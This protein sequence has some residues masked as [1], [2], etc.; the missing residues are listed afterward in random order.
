MTAES[1]NEGTGDLPDPQEILDALANPPGQPALQRAI[2]GHTDSLARMRDRLADP[3]HELTLRSLARAEPGEPAVA[4]LDAWAVVA[5]TVS[6]YSERIANEAFLR[7]AVRLPS[8]REL[9]RTLGYELRPG[10]AAQVELAF[11]VED[12]PGGSGSASP[13]PAGVVVP[14]GTPVQSIPGP[15]ELPQTFRTTTDLEARAQWNRLVAIDSRPQVQPGSVASVWVRGPAAV[16][17]GDTVLVVSR[18]QAAGGGGS[19]STRQRAVRVVVEVDAAAQPGW[20]RLDLDQAL[21]PEE[22]GLRE[23]VT[24]QAFQRRLRLFGWNAPDHELVTGDTGEWTGFEVT[25]PIELDG[26]HPAILPG[27]RIALTQPGDDVPLAEQYRVVSVQTGGVSRYALSGPV[28]LVELEHTSTLEDTLAQLDRRQALVHAVPIELDA[29]REPDLTPLSGTEL[30]LVPSDPPLPPGRH[31]LLSG[32]DD[33]TGVPVT[34]PAEV[35]GCVVTAPDPDE[36]AS[37]EVARMTVTVAQPL[38]A[39]RRAGLTVS[40][41][42]VLAGHGEDVSQV[43]GSA[44]ARVP[45]PVFRPRRAPLTY[46]RAT[47]AAGARADLIVRV[48]GVAWQEVENL[49]DAG[50][51]DRVYQV[52]Q[53]EDGAV[54]IVL[55]DGVHGA[56]PAT[57]VENVTAEYRVGI[58]AAGAVRAGQVSLLVKRPLGIR[59]VTNPLPSQDWAPPE[60][61]DQTRVNAPLRIR[62]LDRAVSLAD[63]E[64]FARGYAGVGP[65]RADLVWDG[66]S[67]HVLVSLRGSEAAEPSG[68]LIADVRAAL[69]AGRDPGTPLDVLAGEQVW[70][71]IRV[72]MANDPA[73]ERE[74]V[75]AAV[76]GALEAAFGPA[77]RGFGAPVSSA[78]VLVVVRNVPGVAACTVPRLFLLTELPAVPTPPTLPADAEA[79]PVIVAESGR[80]LDGTLLPAQ[81]V[82]L[83]PGG[84]EIGVMS[85]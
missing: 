78:A 60:T 58:G 81:L 82:A 1:V 55:G 29:W 4:L 20:T 74:P 13:A 44:D 66:R 67:N 79:S 31:L 85:A 22:D 7:T 56:R 32:I 39:L 68:D 46:V 25:D 6:F 43:L 80:Y 52:Q 73:H 27:S 38:P 24:V 35:V 50:P 54:R 76:L 53:E 34:V 10:V 63:H 47:T 65:A 45:F 57:G 33:A 5:D 26:D 40:A 42:A 72:E 83:A 14:I 59:S 69:Q 62:T 48:D 75:E 9:A 28:T 16:R 19:A 2:A 12:P 17:P 71:G 61:L 70:F 84:V 30:D 77:V 49:L 11:T 37:A 8:V 51:A 41:N 18:P 36:P 3:G 23:L 21:D 15:G 64:D